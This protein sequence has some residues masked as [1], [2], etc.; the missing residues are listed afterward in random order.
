MALEEPVYRVAEAAAL[1][2]LSRSTIYAAVAT[3][4][5]EHLRWGR[6][7]RIPARSLRTWME[8]LTVRAEPSG[9]VV[10]PHTKATRT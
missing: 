5:L 8:R 9:L 10:T 1:T 6:S 2:G 3:K 7:I 4:Q